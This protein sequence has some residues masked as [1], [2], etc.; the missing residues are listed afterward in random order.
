MKSW[1]QTGMTAPRDVM[2]RGAICVFD[3]VSIMNT[4]PISLLAERPRMVSVRL[5][6][7]Q[8]PGA[9]ELC[10]SRLIPHGY[11]VGQRQ[12]ISMKTAVRGIGAGEVDIGPARVTRLVSG[13]ELGQRGLVGHP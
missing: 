4:E 5:S 6:V 12:W 10:A 8:F 11:F 1:R 3:A 7:P 2:G 9:L 13:L